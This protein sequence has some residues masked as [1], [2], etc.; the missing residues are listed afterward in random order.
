MTA[1]KDEPVRYTSDSWA[2]YQLCGTCEE[3]LNKRYEAYAVNLLRGKYSPKVSE[4]GVTF[5]KIDQGLLRKYF[6]SIIWRAVL[7]THPAYDNTSMLPQ[8]LEYIRFA[9]LN[10][11]DIP[12]SKYTVKVHRVQDM[13]S[14][15]TFTPQ[16]IK[17]LIV[18]P[19][20]RTYSN[21]TNASVCLLF[22]GFFV[23][24]FYKAVAPKE[25]RGFGVLNSNSSTLFVPFVNIFSI[26]EIYD[27]MAVGY[28]KH[29]IGMTAVT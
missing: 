29:Q 22:E 6:L 11:L 19:F 1:E 15:P 27:L 3:L 9:L 4:T 26:K 28:N 18:S 17:E 25:R 2:E 8:D 10:D 20:C 5:D 23:E 16:T 12:N 13:S 24:V 14:S 21:P 7:S